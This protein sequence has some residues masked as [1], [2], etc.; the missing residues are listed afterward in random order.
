MFGLKLVLALVGVFAIV[1]FHPTEAASL[2]EGHKLNL[3]ANELDGGSQ[4]NVP[5]LAQELQQFGLDD[6]EKCSHKNP[7]TDIESREIEFGIFSWIGNK[8]QIETTSLGCT[9]RDC[10]QECST[11]SECLDCCSLQKTYCDM[12]C[13]ELPA[14]CGNKCE[15]DYQ[16][17]TCDCLIQHD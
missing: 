9:W 7:G 15:E 1:S 6:G 2:P 12:A 14:I 11:I 4:S 5:Q 10:P 16:F 3:A 17:C 8:N 13:A